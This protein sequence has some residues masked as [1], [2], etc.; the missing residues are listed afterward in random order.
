MID[1]VLV[2]INTNLRNRD[3]IKD[4]LSEHG[5]ISCTSFGT[6]SPPEKLAVVI[7]EYLPN[8][9]AQK[10]IAIAKEL[11]FTHYGYFDNHMERAE[12]EVLF[13]AYGDASRYELT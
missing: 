1:N 5:V 12:E 11:G 3:E 6:N 13:G 2:G 7:S 9:V 8:S 10:F 4:K